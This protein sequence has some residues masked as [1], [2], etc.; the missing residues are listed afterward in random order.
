MK[1]KSIITIAVIV[2]IVVLA[3][4]TIISIRD[5]YR[6][7]EEQYEEKVYYVKSGDTLW[8]LAGEFC[9]EKDDIRVWIDKVTE[10]NGINCNLQ[11]GQRIIVFVKK[12]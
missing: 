2:L 1:N 8:E 6:F 9:Y 3:V 4:I 10:Y 11:V 7:H 12:G 5:K